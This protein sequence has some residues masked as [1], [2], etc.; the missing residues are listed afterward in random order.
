MND[1]SMNGL[2]GSEIDRTAIQEPTTAVLMCF[3]DCYEH[4]TFYHELS[5]KTQSCD[6]RGL[7]GTN[8]YCD[9]E[10]MEILTEQIK[11]Y[12]LK[13]I[14]FLDSGNYHYLTRIWID[15]IRQPF[16]LLV[17]DNHTDLQPAAFGSILS[18]GGWIDHAL[19]D[20]AFLEEVV[21]VGPDTASWLEVEE[22]KRK[23]IKFLSR[24]KIAE[25]EDQEWYTFFQSLSMDHPWYLSID[26]DILCTEEA[27]TGWSQGDLRLQTLINALRS[28]RE[29]CGMQKSV[30]LG[31]DI[32]GECAPKEH[33]AMKNDLANKC[34]LEE[35][36]KFYA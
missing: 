19:S 20:L 32:C 26:K 25:M 15:R 7:S 28:F 35:L 13:G 11:K 5:V 1:R 21:L 22:D 9:Q 8:C 10:A 31:A 12:P 16:R 34:L 4:Q 29:S 33:G 14:H 23:K 18:C 27:V 6:L 24:E 36:L 2:K 3:S 30:L 17:F